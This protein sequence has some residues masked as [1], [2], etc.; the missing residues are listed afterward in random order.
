MTQWLSDYERLAERESSELGA[1]ELQQRATAAYML[2]RYQES[3]DSWDRAHSVL[4][5]EGDAAG[6]SRCLFWL[7]LAIGE[8]DVSVAPRMGGQL[9]RI[10][11][12]VE[13]FSL[14]EL[15]Q[16]YLDCYG[17]IGKF[18]SGEYDESVAA[19]WARIAGIGRA[20]ADDDIWAF[21]A[22]GH[23]RTLIRMGRVREGTAVLDELF[24]AIG[25]GAV[26]PMMAG[27]VYCSCLEACQEGFDLQ[28]A[29]EWTRSANRW[30]DE[31]GG[32]ETYTGVCLLH[33]SRIRRMLGSWDDALQDADRACV[34]LS[35]GR[36]HFFLGAAHY[37]RGE[38]LRLRGDHRGAEDG[39]RTASQYG[40]DPQPGLA[41]LRLAQGKHLAAGAALRRALD[42][43]ADPCRR[44]ELLPARAEVALVEADAGAAAAACAELEELA[45]SFGS[46]L[47][48]AE[49]LLL[50]GRIALA[51]ADPRTA[52]EPLRTAARLWHD[53]ESP[54]AGART[55]V[56]LA[57]AC[58]ALGDV[59]GAEMELT[60][61]RA[62]F[63]AIGAQD[64]LAGLRSD[65]HARSPLSER[66]IEVVRKVATGL[67]NRAVAT[68]LHIS[69]KTVAS[70]LSHIFTKLDVPNRAAV[71]AYYYEE[72]AGNR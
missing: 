19:A 13:E 1:D 20:H 14:G 26:S 57:A 44:A 15:E 25:S 70:H 37:H 71:T 12:L 65:G 34:Q 22:Q 32:L 21:G 33:R 45:E 9:A 43:T 3:V 56:H 54:L 30:A 24:V 8:D 55:R 39:Y 6:A 28:R 46:R 23:G 5:N 53:L 4:L 35:E 52:L 59:E 7:L 41:L 29:I 60:S 48:R 69:E 66:E 18:M 64:D 42:E 72:L 38:I 31:Q 49:A 58:A 51:A 63:E 11:R 40:H 50:R 61:A 47:L 2:G 17:C 68:Q 16:A 10:Q 27:W 36:I 67:S 62:V